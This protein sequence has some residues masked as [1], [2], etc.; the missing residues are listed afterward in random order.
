MG[1]QNCGTS[2]QCSFKNKEEC[3]SLAKPYTLD[4][5]YSTALTETS[6]QKSTQHILSLSKQTFLFLA[7]EMSLL[8]AMRSDEDCCTV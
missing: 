1:K 3:T 5:S 2:I 8:L 7:T 4:K 6:T